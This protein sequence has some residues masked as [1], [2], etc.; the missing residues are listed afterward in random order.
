MIQWMQAPSCKF[1]GKSRPLYYCLRRSCRKYR[2]CLVEYLLCRSTTVVSR[3]PP[4]A[5]SG[6]YQ[7]FPTLFAIVPFIAG[8]NRESIITERNRPSVIFVLL[9]VRFRKM[10]L[11]QVERFL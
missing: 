2:S 6:D 8:V 11:Q 5:T 7:A 10:P 9:Y 3:C 4:F 1:G